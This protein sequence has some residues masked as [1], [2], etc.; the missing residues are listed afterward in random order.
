MLSME[1]LSKN[2]F[3]PDNINI[4]RHIAITSVNTKNI[5]LYK[6]AGVAK[7][8]DAPG[9]GPGPSRGGGS[10]PFARTV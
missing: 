9:L 7:L 1:K 3:L 2:N 5:L 4:D 8:A 10:S 6:Y